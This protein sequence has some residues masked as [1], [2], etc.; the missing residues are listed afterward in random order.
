[1][2]YVY[3]IWIY[4]KYI[5]NIIY[6]YIIYIID[7]CIYIG[8]YLIKWLTKRK[9]YLDLDLRT[10]TF[11]PLFED[12]RLTDL[13]PV[14]FHTS[15]EPKNSKRGFSSRFGRFRH[16]LWVGWALFFH[17]KMHFKKFRGS[18]WWNKTF[19]C[20]THQTSSFT[21]KNKTTNQLNGCFSRCFEGFAL[22]FVRT[23]WIRQAETLE[24]V[25]WKRQLETKKWGGF[26][27]AC[28]LLS[29][30]GLLYCLRGWLTEVRRRRPHPT[31]PTK[32]KTHTNQLVLTRSVNTL[33]HA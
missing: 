30:M 27:L 17:K 12:W 7:I 19:I 3:V 20:I 21:P 9:W 13:L 16:L 22:A 32:N 6:I 2:I 5:M 11:C 31:Q 1:M 10:K 8:V 33:E 15:Q 18:T 25:G 4:Y 26:C 14:I 23:Y 28:C 29:H 24:E